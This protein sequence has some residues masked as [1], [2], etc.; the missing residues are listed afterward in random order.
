MGSGDET[1]DLP[2]C[3]GCVVCETRGAGGPLVKLTTEVFRLVEGMCKVANHSCV[4]N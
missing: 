2:L 3:E 4:H 1:K